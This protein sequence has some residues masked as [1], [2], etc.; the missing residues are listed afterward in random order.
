MI[1]TCICPEYYKKGENFTSGEG[2]VTTDNVLKWINL[3]YSE[4]LETMHENFESSF[5]YY[6]GESFHDDS[7]SSSGPND[8]GYNSWEDLA[9]NEAFEGNSDAWGH[10]NQ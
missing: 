5:C 3:R 2:V 9:F 10:H 7:D 1:L 4:R 8:Y 6:D